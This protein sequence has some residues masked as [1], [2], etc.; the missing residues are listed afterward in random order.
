MWNGGSEF[1]CGPDDQWTGWGEEMGDSGAWV[2][3]VFCQ[4]WTDEREVARTVW[5]DLRCKGISVE[6][7]QYATCRQTSIKLKHT[8]EGLIL[9]LPSYI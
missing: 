5:V 7:R 8:R 1:R 6:P 4:V 3:G 9:Y 2:E